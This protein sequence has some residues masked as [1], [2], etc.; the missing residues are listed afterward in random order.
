MSRL[1]S[2][3]DGYMDVWQPA[4]FEVNFVDHRRI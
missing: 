1:D 3:G 2:Y 4:V